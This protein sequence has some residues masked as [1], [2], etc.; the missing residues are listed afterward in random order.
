MYWPKEN[1]RKLLDTTEGNWERKTNQET[2]KHLQDAVGQD[3][4]YIVGGTGTRDI[5]SD[6]NC[7]S[8]IFY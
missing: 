7:L 4:A 3:N 2:I 5:A 8:V 6:N 1:G